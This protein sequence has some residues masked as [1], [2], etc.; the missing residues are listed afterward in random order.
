[1]SFNPIQKEI[2]RLKEEK[3]A[4]ILA[5]YYQNAQVQ[6][7]ADHVGDSFAL[8]KLA[9]ELPEEIIVFCGVSFMAETAKI[10]SPFKTVLLPVSHA[11]CPM[12][13]M[14]TGADVLRLKAEHPDAAVVSYVNSSTDVKA[15]SDI[16]CTSANAVNVIRSLPHR[17]IIFLPDEN[18]G[19]YAAE[20]IPEKEFILFAGYCPTHEQVMAIDVKLARDENPEALLL[21]HPE[22]RQDVRREAD[23]LGSTGQILK[24]VDQSQHPN[25]IIGTEKGILHPLKT[26]H[27]D[28]RFTLL[29]KELICPNMKKTRPEHVLD[30]LKH[31]KGEV[32]LDEK[33][34]DAARIP[35]VRMLQVS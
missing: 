23:F 6:D 18:L 34:M 10:I 7:V 11:G 14:A 15:L 27:P 13:D 4:V 30:S 2:L 22:C 28:K 29:A 21:V 16:C 3:N 19:A 25:F 33:L 17:K 8:S 1:M 24:Y 5:H 32:H 20:R 12:A 9:A 35:L 26:K 31:M